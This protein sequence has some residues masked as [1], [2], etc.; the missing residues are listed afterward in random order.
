M[1]AFRVA[2]AV[3]ALAVPGLSQALTTLFASN[4]AGNAGGGI[5]FDVNVLNP[6]GITIVQIDLNC[7]PA[8]GTG[9]VPGTL[10][11]FT[12]PG[13]RVTNQTNFGAW[14]GPSSLGNALTTAPFNTPTTV[15]LMTPLQLAQGS[16]GL[17]FRAN[18]FANAYTNG[19]GNNQNFGNTDLTIA[20]GEASNV[21]FTAP[22]FSPRVVNCTIHYSPGGSGTLLSLATPYGA[23]CVD[24]YTSF[25]ENFQP[26]TM[27]LGNSS[28]SMFNTGTGYLVLSG[29]ASYVV[30]PAAATT[31]A[32]SND[33]EVTVAL[34]APMPVAG[35]TTTNLTVCSNGFVSV[36]IGNGI[37]ALP[38]VA[39][40]LAMPRTV[41]ASWHDYDPFSASSGRVKFH[42][43][44]G[45]AYVTWDGVFD[46]LSTGS[47]TF[48]VQF[49]LASGHVHFVWRAMS[50]QGNGHLVGYSPGGPS[51]DPGNR[52]LSATLA[53]SIALGTTDIVPLAFAVSPRPIVNTTIQL[54]TSNLEPTTAVGAVALGFNRL[55]PPTNLTSVGMAGCF[56]YHDVLATYLYV[57]LG[58]ASVNTP[59]VVPNLLGLQLQ[60]QSYC[61]DP[62]STQTLLG[63]RSSRAFDLRCGD[64]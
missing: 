3:V 7:G 46:S 37:S 30:P 31:L 4:N 57:P 45:T 52:D 19:T 48:Q 22:V 15:L 11:V 62:A 40:F 14:N 27:D 63:A 38:H 53:G 44:S 12:I 8:A 29:V 43:A 56:Q 25:Y 5:Y 59:L 9:G 49:D 39:S 17:A 33:S 28:M 1:Q 23:G 61:Y 34:A 16:W 47:S 32:L 50:T 13:T 2:L 36:G 20:C 24:S 54:T 60:A 51:R 35:G 26:G 21:P 55:M 64:F 41:F 6:A 18:G 58:A 42:Q 10:D